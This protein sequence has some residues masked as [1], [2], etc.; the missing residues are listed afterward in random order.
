MAIENSASQIIAIFFIFIDLTEHKQL[1]AA[2]KPI[3]EFSKL[4]LKAAGMSIWQWNLKTREIVSV[5][6]LKNIFGLNP[7]TFCG[8]FDTLLDYIHPDDYQKLTSVVNY[9]CDEH[10]DY[11]IEF[12]LLSGGSILWLL[13]SSHFL[14][15]ETGQATQMLGIVQDI[16]ERKK[17][18]ELFREREA[19]N[20]EGQGKRI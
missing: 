6:N 7:E 9:A 4:A 18:E 1:E 19:T 16:T 15:D 17:S 2:L 13:A 10:V 11:N 3:E 12:R 5:G 8:N 14:Y 20:P